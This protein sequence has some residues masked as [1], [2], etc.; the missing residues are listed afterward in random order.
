MDLYQRLQGNEVFS[1]LVIQLP[2]RSCLGKQLFICT[3]NTVADEL[4]V[5][6]IKDREGDEQNKLFLPPTNSTI[7]KLPGNRLV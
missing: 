6:M 2:G 5:H 1:L 7:G 3:A 4:H